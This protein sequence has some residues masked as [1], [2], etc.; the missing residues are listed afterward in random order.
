MH[1]SAGLAAIEYERGHIDEALTH[2]TEAQAI[3]EQHGLGEHWA[4]SLSLAVRGQ[5][6]RQRGDLE[7]ADEAIGRA[8]ELAKRGVASVEIAYALLALAELRRQQ[9]LREAAVRLR[10]EARRAVRSCADPG[11]LRELLSRLERRLR[12][13]PAQA[14]ARRTS[15]RGAHR[16]RASG[17][18]TVPQRALSARDRRRAVRLA[19]HRQIS[20]PQHLPQ[21][22]RGDARGGRQAG[23]RALTGVLTVAVVRLAVEELL[24][25]VA[26]AIQRRPRPRA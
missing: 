20:R 12:L 4:K 1:A 16:R 8:V 3:A 7:A 18:P 10:D 15:A 25:R 22:R 2:A 17:P 11:I 21:A 23:S 9:G 14:R 5:V 24:Q 26:E 13:T 19:Q 6:H